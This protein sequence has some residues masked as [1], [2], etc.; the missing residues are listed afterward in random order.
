MKKKLF[1]L[2]VVLMVMPNSSFAK[3]SLCEGLNSIY[4]DLDCVDASK[5]GAICEPGED[6]VSLPRKLQLCCCIRL[7]DDSS[8]DSSDDVTDP[9]VEDV[10]SEEGFRL[11]NH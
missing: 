10:S 3:S 7:S 1:A 8:D 5:S 2:L 11:K 6:I 4:E 9:S